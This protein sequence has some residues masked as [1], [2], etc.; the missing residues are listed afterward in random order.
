MKPTN[1]G[2]RTPDVVPPDNPKSLED[3]I[4]KHRGPYIGGFATNKDLATVIRSYLIGRLPKEI[5]ELECDGDYYRGYNKALADVRKA[6]E[7]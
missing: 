5:S 3:M 2:L 6:L 7:I 1:A 4:E